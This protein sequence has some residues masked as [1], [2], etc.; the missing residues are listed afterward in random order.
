MEPL[1]S[2]ARTAAGAPAHGAG[3]ADLLRHL[4]EYGYP[5]HRLRRGCWTEVS[6]ITDDCRN[7]LFTA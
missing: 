7:H 5:P 3:P 4:R 2:P 6:R 1:P